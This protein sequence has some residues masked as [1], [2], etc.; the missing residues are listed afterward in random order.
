MNKPLNEICENT[1]NGN[2]S[3]HEIRNE[4]IQKMQTEIQLE[5]KSL[6]SQPKT[7]EIILA[8][9]LKDIEERI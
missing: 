3:R 1:N 2:S 9:R 8:N 7:S 5:S 6:Q 4:I